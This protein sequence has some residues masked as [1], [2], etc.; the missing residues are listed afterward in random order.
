MLRATRIPVIGCPDVPDA[1]K[2]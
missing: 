2:L 1:W